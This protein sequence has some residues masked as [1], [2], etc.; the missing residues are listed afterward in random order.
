MVTEK[1]EMSF[2]EH[3]GVLRGHL[4]RSVI[5]IFI[6]TVLAFLN[7]IFSLIEFYWH[8]KNPILLP[9][10]YYVEFLNGLI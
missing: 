5:A 4:I 2:L 6:F 8:Q 7:K 3:L 10:D 9:I 1:A